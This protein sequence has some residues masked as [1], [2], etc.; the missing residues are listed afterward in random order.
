M[1]GV[2]GSN[3][4]ASTILKMQENQGVSALWFSFLVYQAGGAELTPFDLQGGGQLL[5]SL[6]SPG[7]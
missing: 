2:G 1:E 3:P 7:G 6:S 4:S 5:T